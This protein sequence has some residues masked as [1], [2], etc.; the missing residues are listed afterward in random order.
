MD[1]IIPTHSQARPLAD[2]LAEEMLQHLER[3][4]AE[5]GIRFLGPGSGEQG[6]VHVIGP[7]RGLTQPGMTICRAIHLHARGVRRHRLGI[8]PVVRNVLATQC[9]AMD[10]S[11]CAASR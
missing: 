8:A 5:H 9:L 4:C 6:I 7:E 1:H 11:A 2:P 3:N 10:S